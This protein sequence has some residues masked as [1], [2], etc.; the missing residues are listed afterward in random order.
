MIVKLPIFSLRIC[1]E[2]CFSSLHCELM[3]SKGKVFVNKFDF[4]RVFIQHLLE[5]RFKTRAIGSLVVTE[6]C[7]G[8]RGMLGAFKRKSGDIY[9]VDNFQLND[10]QCFSR[11]TP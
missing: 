2:R 5:Q 8:Y 1:C 6:D 11:M 4:V 3:I 7:D 9:R 10:F